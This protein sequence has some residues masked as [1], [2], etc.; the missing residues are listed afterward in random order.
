MAYPV[1]EGWCVGGAPARRP[2]AVPVHDRVTLTAAD[3]AF[4]GKCLYSL[5]ATT[6]IKGGYYQDVL[7]PENSQ[8]LNFDKPTESINMPLSI[9]SAVSYISSSVEKWV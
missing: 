4:T 8:S 7:F 9:L 1:T 2:S 3:S 6:T 5:K